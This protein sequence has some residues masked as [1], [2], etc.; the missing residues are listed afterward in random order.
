MKCHNCDVS[1][2]V[3]NIPCSFVVV[4]RNFRRNY[5]EPGVLLLWETAA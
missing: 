5:P 1:I 3:L 2:I 4:D